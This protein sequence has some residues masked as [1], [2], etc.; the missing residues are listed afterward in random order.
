MSPGHISP[1]NARGVMLVEKMV[2]TLIKKESIG[3][4]DPILLRCEMKGR[5]VFICKDARG[6]MRIHGAYLILFI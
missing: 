3:I 5:A 2:F 1:E 4:V 6:W